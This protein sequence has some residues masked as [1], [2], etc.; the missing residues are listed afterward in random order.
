MGGGAVRDRGVAR[1]IWERHEA[2]AEKAERRK[3]LTAAANAIA[4][5]LKQRPSR[6]LSSVREE[7]LDGHLPTAKQLETVN[8]IMADRGL[9][10]VRCPAR[11]DQAAEAQARMAF[12][13]QE[14]KTAAQKL[15]ELQ[16]QRPLQPPGRKVTW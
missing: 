2:K 11:G 6:F 9:P 10:K 1:D 5:A 12:T 14:R 4:R 7:L 13:L 16:S 3:A 8:A 15:S